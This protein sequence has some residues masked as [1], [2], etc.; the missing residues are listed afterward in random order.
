M[1]LLITSGDTAGEL[2]QEAGVDGVL[3][4]C[5]DVLHD[6]P[7]PAGPDLGDPAEIRA[8]H[9]AGAGGAAYEDMLADLRSRRCGLGREC[10]E[11][12]CNR[13]SVVLA[14]GLF[15]GGAADRT[16]GRCSRG[17]GQRRTERT[18]TDDY[19]AIGP[20]EPV[21]VPTGRRLRALREIARRAMECY[22]AAPVREVCVQ[23]A[24]AEPPRWKPAQNASSSPRPRSARL[25]QA[26]CAVGAT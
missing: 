20:G 4:P 11:I 6:G 3:L 15:P 23:S 21:S 13:L 19:Q 1:R 14:A 5:S 17:E 9:L 18:E 22:T 2:L 24:S 16:I 12:A 26:T 25:V 7:V 10:R 8:G